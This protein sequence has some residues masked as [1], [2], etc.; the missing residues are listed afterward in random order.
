MDS[1]A[2]ISP[3]GTAMARGITPALY[4]SC[5][6]GALRSC[7]ALPCIVMLPKDVVRLRWEGSHVGT[8]ASW[9][10]PVPSAVTIRGCVVGDS[11]G[12][13][14]ASPSEGPAERQPASQTAPTTANHR[15]KVYV[16]GGSAY[17][18]TITYGSANGYPWGYLLVFVG[19]HNW[20]KRSKVTE[21]RLNERCED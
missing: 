18:H 12:G 4:N 14:T 15:H 11:G 16:C 17:I 9:H 20:W 8:V 3:S 2:F 5:P 1:G 13:A 10:I 6:P 19:V 21:K 7:T